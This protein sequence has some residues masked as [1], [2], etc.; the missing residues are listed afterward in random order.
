MVTGHLA[1]DLPVPGSASATPQMVANERDTAPLRAVPTTWSDDEF[2]AQVEQAAVRVS[3]E[4]LHP[5]DALT[6]RSWEVAR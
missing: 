3:P 5:L 1:H 4:A 2:L 6:P